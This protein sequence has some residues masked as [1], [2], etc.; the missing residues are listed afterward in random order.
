VERQEDVRL[1]REKAQESGR[2][3][4]SDEEAAKHNTCELFEIDAA[5]MAP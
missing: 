2:E 4:V 1:S 5:A 3:Q